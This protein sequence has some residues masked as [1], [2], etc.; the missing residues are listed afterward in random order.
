[1]RRRMLCAPDGD[2]REDRTP[3]MTTT[4]RTLPAVDAPERRQTLSTVRESQMA[5]IPAGTFWMG[6]NDFYPEE[7]PVHRVAV[8][9]FWI[10]RSPVT[11]VDFAEFVG[12]TGYVTVA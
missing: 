6:S 10:D 5:W 7:H 12:E 4:L 8:D 2:F 9:G 3:T 1:M 11:T